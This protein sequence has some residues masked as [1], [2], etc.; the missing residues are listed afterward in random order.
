MRVALSTY[1][2][3]NCGASCQQANETQDYAY[4]TYGI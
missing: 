1:P 4:P 3:S 2:G